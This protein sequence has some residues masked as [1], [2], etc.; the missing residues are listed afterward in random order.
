MERFFGPSPAHDIG[1]CDTLSRRRN[2]I[3]LAVTTFAVVFVYL[4]ALAVQT[5]NLYVIMYKQRMYR[6]VHMSWQ[7][8]FGSGVLLCKLAQ[9]YYWCIVGYRIKQRGYCGMDY[10][11]LIRHKEGIIQVVDD[12]KYGFFMCGF[13]LLFKMCFGL[14]TAGMIYSVTVRMRI[15]KHKLGSDATAKFD[16]SFAILTALVVLGSTAYMSYWIRVLNRERAS[17]NFLH[18]LRDGQLQIDVAEAEM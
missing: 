9:I 3:A 8:V 2:W 5:R 4:F 16:R 17:Q 14:L 15:I 12:M 11:Q 1:W 6:S 7:Y 10:L 18:Y 13:S